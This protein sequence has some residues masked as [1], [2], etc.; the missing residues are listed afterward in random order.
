[1]HCRHYLWDYSHVH[2]AYPI[3]S[4][5]QNQ[6]KA[7]MGSFWSFFHAPV[8]L[9]LKLC[10]M[11]TCF[12]HIVKNVWKLKSHHSSTVE[13]FYTLFGVFIIL[14]FW[15]IILS[16]NILWLWY[17]WMWLCVVEC[18]LRH[19]RACLLQECSIHLYVFMS[20]S[21]RVSFQEPIWLTYLV[22]NKLQM[23]WKTDVYLGILSRYKS[24]LMNSETLPQLSHHRTHLWEH[25]VF[26]CSS[27]AVRTIPQG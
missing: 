4:H 2:S 13:D 19:M 5:C 14:T 18:Q 16:V 24:C 17:I 12:G 26:L 9:S 15:S 1:M 11:I 6:W 27:A 3:F 7:S 25:S 22:F 10:S 20:L 23:S 21:C 8:V